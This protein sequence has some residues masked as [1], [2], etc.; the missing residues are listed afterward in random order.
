MLSFES[1]AREYATLFDSMEIT[2]GSVVASQVKRIMDFIDAYKEVEAK[3]GVPWVVIGIM[4]LRESGGGACRHLHNGDSLR[5]RT[6]N[7]PSNRPKPGTGPFTFLDSACDAVQIKGLHKITEW[8][9]ERMAYEFERYNGFGYRQYRS[10]RSPYLWGG[11]SHQQPGKYIR[12]GVFDKTVMDKQIG[13]MPLLKELCDVAGVVI[14]SMY[15]ATPD[16]DKQTAASNAKTNREMSTTEKAV[17]GTGFTAA[18]VTTT[19]ATTK[20]GVGVAKEIQPLLTVPM[21]GLIG[22]IAIGGLFL[23]WVRK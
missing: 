18:T 16:P 9:I 19:I 10:M 12:D 23:W 20:E 5:K 6:V 13:C 11:T 4:D 8:T 17:I 7:V 22:I 3:T 14:P 21:V 1:I 2:R 15:D